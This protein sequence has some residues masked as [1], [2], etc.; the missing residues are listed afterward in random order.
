[1][2]IRR[3]GHLVEMLVGYWADE[4]VFALVEFSGVQLECCEA[5]M[6]VN[7]VDGDMVALKVESMVS[8]VAVLR[9]AQKGEVWVAKMD[10]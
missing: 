1:M 9:V 6:R 10:D 4:K 5:A 3:V 2:E 8:N 7:S